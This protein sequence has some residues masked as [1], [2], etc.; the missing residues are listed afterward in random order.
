MPTLTQKGQVTIP[1]H[2][3]D[4]L[5]LSQGDEVIFE[6][7]NKRAIMKK[8]KKTAQFRKYVGYLKHLEGENTDDIVRGLRD[9]SEV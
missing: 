3:R 6:I 5:K 1:K 4:A 8:R 9:E 2:V 7:N